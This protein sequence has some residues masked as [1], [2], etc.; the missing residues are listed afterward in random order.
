MV[1]HTLES[2][3]GKDYSTAVLVAVG[4]TSLVQTLVTGEA[5]FS[6]E[7]FMQSVV[8]IG[9]PTAVGAL[10]ANMITTFEP[11]VTQDINYKK[12]A[13]RAAIAGGVA[14][15]VLIL[16]GALPMQ[17]DTQLISLAALVGLGTAAGDIVAH[18][19]TSIF[20]TN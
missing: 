13:P 15:G 1:N 14:C 16:S 8:Q 10:V 18:D 5:G 11:S 9:G 7:S 20:P 3:I 12:L 2:K 19:W 4:A 6:G 17:V